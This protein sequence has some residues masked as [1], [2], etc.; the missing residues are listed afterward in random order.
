MAEPQPVVRSGAAG[1]GL[2]AAPARA[3]RRLVPAGGCARR[4]RFRRGW[5]DS[6]RASSAE[7]LQLY[8]QIA[9]QG[10]ADIGCAPDEYAGFTMTLLRM[11]AFAPAGA[12]GARAQ[13]PAAPG[14][15]PRNGPRLHHR[16][17]RRAR[18]PQL[19]APTPA[20]ARILRLNR[21]TS[22]TG[23]RSWDRSAGRAWRACWRSTAS[24]GAA[25]TAASSCA[26]RRRTSTCMEKA[27]QE[28]LQAALKE[29]LGAMLRRVEITVGD[30]R[31][32]HAGRARSARNARRAQRRR[33][34]RSTATRSCANWSKTSTGASFPNPSN[35]CREA[36]SHCKRNR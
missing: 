14:V 28:K 4:S 1:T 6:R 35:R 10:R 24:C 29:R 3:A 8:Y 23:P 31:R 5:R 17:R 18:M 21:C 27:Y 2:A 15:G 16:R 33:S 22:R 9:L 7:D 11:L 34:R 13:P 20:A 36:R 32:Q 26:C 25:R 19:C 12:E 30:R